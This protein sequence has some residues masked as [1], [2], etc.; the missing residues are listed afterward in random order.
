MRKTACHLHSR[1]LFRLRLGAL[2]SVVTA[3]FLVASA[4]L[5]AQETLACNFTAPPDEVA[6]RVSP[7]DSVSLTAQHGE[8]KVCYSRPSARGREIMGG[9]VPYGTPWRLGA[10]EATVVHVT[11]PAEIG[12]VEVEPG[13]YSLFAVPGE[14]EWEIV[15]NSDTG[16]W[17]NRITEDVRADDVG[18]ATVSPKRTDEHVETFTIDLREAES[19]VEMV[20]EWERTRLVVPIRPRG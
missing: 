10:N 12:G 17:G 15:V 6:E 9:L 3:G 20:L 13:S 4:P 8:V 2:A 14:E 19:G 18:S 1:D 7:G 5:A 11:F 16:H